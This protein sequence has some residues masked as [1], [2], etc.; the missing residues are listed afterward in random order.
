MEEA[1]L[2]ARMKQSAEVGDYFERLISR[3]EYLL[4]TESNRKRGAIC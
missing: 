3:R 4:E 1:W 2:Q